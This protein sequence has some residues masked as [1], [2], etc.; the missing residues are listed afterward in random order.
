M[1]RC[2]ITWFNRWLTEILKVQ[3]IDLCHLILCICLEFGVGSYWR[4]IYPECVTVLF[5]SCNA[6]FYLP[7]MFC[8][9][10]ENSQS[11]CQC[12]WKEFH[13]INFFFFKLYSEWFVS[14]VRI[15][16]Q[17]RFDSL[18]VVVWEIVTDP[19]VLRQNSFFNAFSFKAYI[20]KASATFPS[21]LSNDCSMS[22]FYNLSP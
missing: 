12:Y 20:K 11:I 18:N 2:E 7:T 15:F 22:V 4:S 9:C 10:L 16:S 1:I 3:T 8:K 21:L 19:Q 13:F 14:S 17:R 5:V 6:S